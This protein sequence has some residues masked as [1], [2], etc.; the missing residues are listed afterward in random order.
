M[1]PAGGGGGGGGSGGSSALASG[2][3]D[4]GLGQPGNAPTGLQQVCLPPPSPAAKRAAAPHRPALLQTGADHCLR[5]CDRDKH[6]IF[7]FS[8]I[9]ACCLEI[10]A[11]GPRYGSARAR[12]SYA[13]VA[14]VRPLQGVVTTLQ[15]M[16]SHPR[17]LQQKARHR[18]KR[19]RFRS[20]QHRQ[21]VPLSYACKPTKI[22]KKQ[23]RANANNASLKGT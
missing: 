7:D 11:E 2:L 20:G 3:R 14:N 9:Y 21:A 23:A 8:H 16:G 10:H 6:V 12:V 5:P 19:L 17:M 4:S 13:S 15:T 22:T 1:A 18:T